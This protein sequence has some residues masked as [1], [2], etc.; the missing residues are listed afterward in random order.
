[1][2]D[3]NLKL[4]NLLVSHTQ[5]VVYE[6]CTTHKTWLFIIRVKRELKRVYR[7]AT[8]RLFIINR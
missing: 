5:G 3:Y 2:K 8:H 1:M 4:R 6:S 7:N